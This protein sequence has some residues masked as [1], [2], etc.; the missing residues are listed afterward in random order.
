MIPLALLAPWVASNEARYGALTATALAKTLQAPVV[1]PTGAH[2]GLGSVLAWLGRF[3]RPL[4]PQEWWSQYAGAGVVLRVVPALLLL[5]A[6][7]P[8][9][10]Q[11]APRALAARPPCSPRRWRSGS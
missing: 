8:L 4:L 10:A 3:E 1:D 9:A 7:I 5:A 11:A 2:Y 6:L